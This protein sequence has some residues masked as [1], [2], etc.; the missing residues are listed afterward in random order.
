MLLYTEA[1]LEPCNTCLS[2]AL[3]LPSLSTSFLS[4]CIV[5]L[6]FTGKLLS[7]FY[8]ISNRPFTLVY[9]WSDQNL[10]FFKFSL[11]RIGLDAAMIVIQLGA[12]VYFLVTISFLRA[13]KSKRP[14]L[15]LV[16]RWNIKLLLMLLQKL[17]GCV[18]FFLSLVPLLLALQCY[19]WQH[20]CHLFVV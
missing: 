14:L 2:L 19:V 1:L 17:C 18:L 9:S 3:T 4:L 20:W 15:G 5:Q 10:T 11:T 6:P 7:D 13:A 12:F 8:G 16:Q